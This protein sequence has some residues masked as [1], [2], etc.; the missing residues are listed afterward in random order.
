[1]PY[2]PA[3]VVEL[4]HRAG[5]RGLVVAP[6]LDL[7]A[8]PDAPVRDVVEGELDDELALLLRRKAARVPDLAQALAV[9]EAED[10]RADRPLGLARAPAEDDRVDRAH[11]LDL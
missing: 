2:C 1:M 11:A 3:L 8:V 7:C 5:L 6:A 9:V 4:I 10:D